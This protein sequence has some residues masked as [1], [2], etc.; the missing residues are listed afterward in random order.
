MELKNVDICTK[1]SGIDAKELDG[2]A[3]V[4]TGCIQKCLKKFPELSG[5]VFGYV[6]GEFI[7]CDTKEEFLAKL[8]TGGSPAV[9]ADTN[10]KVDE[11]IKDAEKWQAEFI[12][13]RRI[14]LE[15]G[16]TEELKWGQP[17]YMHG[18]TNLIILGGFKQYV[19]INFVKGV[20]LKDVKG[21]LIQQTENVQEARQLRFT[22]VKEITDLEDVIK[23]YI[24]EAVEYEKA[25]VKVVLEKKPEMA[26]PEELTAK[27]NENPAFKTAFEALT[28]G[29]QRGY[30]FNF[31]QPKQAKTREA[32]IEK[33]V[34]QIFDGKGI[35]D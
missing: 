13:L 3:T 2:K 25:G 7:V 23:A 19:A 33:Y 10:P 8:E 11:F 15:C 22:S 32:R 27:F 35:D 31:S 17:C 18:K 4:K 14:V 6:S 9:S 16:L 34:Q 24:N 30:I 1:C 5:K 26:V 20:L 28:P 12:E 29:R 21:I